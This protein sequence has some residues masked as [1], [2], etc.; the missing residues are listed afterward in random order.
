MTGNFAKI[1]KKHSKRPLE[2]DGYRL[3]GEGVMSL[4]SRWTRHLC[5]LLFLTTVSVFAAS[6]CGDIRT[7]EAEVHGIAR[8]KLPALPETGSHKVLVFSEMHYQPSYKSQEGPRVLPH[9][10]S[11]PVTGRELRYGN[12]DE[13]GLLTMPQSVSE[14]YDGAV[15]EEVYRVNCLMCH[16]ANMRGEGPTA[17]VMEKR[18]LSPLPADLTLEMTQGALPGEIFA[19]ITEGGRQG[20]ALIEKG[21]ESASPM[22]AFQ[23]LLTEQE[24]WMLV[25]YI[26]DR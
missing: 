11:V 19:F 12:L 18:G 10:E 16:G 20:Y 22:P 13:Y 4:I 21:R 25:K 6:A 26:L 17:T 3:E 23:F 15:V 14:S 1:I 2:S 9:P 24:R 5:V 7:G 8:F